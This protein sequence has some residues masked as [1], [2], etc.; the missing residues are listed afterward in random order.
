MLTRSWSIDE[1]ASRE[2]A[3]RAAPKPAEEAVEHGARLGLAL[4]QRRADDRGEIAD[5]LGDEKIMLHE[6]LDRATG[7]R[8]RDSRDAPPIV[9]C[10]SKESRS[11]ARPVAKCR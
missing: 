10:M 8:G 6:A 11:S 4:F 9:G 3:L 2:R 5:V 7:R 1:V